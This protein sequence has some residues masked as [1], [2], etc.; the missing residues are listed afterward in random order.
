MN[1]KT[2]YIL[3]LADNGLILAQRLGEWC[4]HGPVLEQDIALTNIALDVLG[5]ARYFY[6]Y[7]AEVDGEGKSEDDYA[8]FRNERDFKNFL[9]LEQPNG[10]WSQTIVRQFFYDN[11]MQLVYTKLLSSTD[12]QIAAIASKAI[13][14]VN[15]HLKFSSE[16]IIRMGDGTEESHERVHNA[17]NTLWEFT[18]ELFVHT[19]YEKEMAAEGIGCDVAI[20]KKEWQA[21]V[22]EI[23][24]EATLQVPQATWFQSGGKTGVHSEN[25][26]LLLTDLQY[27]QRT[28]PGNSW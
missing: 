20:L 19:D 6:Q 3:H 26:G 2:N 8:Y 28:Y 18:G 10:D 14:E 25:L 16:W 24:A 21:R 15:Y 9:L 27:L 7:A 22:N 17:V 11:F 12:K 13:K 5:Q 4:G 1:S 23:F